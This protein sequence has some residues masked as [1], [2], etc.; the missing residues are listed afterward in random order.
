MRHYDFQQKI[1]FVD[2]A[3]AGTVITAVVGFFKSFGDKVPNYPIKSTNTLQKLRD[4]VMRNVNLPP[5][6]VAD[7]RIQL[8]RAKAAL[9]REMSGSGVANESIRMMYNEVIAALTNYINSNGS[10]TVPTTPGGGGGSTTLPTNTN[11]SGGYIAPKGNFLTDTS[12]LGLPNWLTLGGAAFAAYYFT[13]KKSR[14]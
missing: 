7:A 3:T 13:R 5:A 2:P 1:G 10:S 9:Q 8:D 11:P 12:L 14:R 6:S 4:E